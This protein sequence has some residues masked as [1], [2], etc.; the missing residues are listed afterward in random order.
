MSTQA[1][2]LSENPQRGA[3]NLG[4]PDPPTLANPAQKAPDHL[5]EYRTAREKRLAEM[6]DK[7]QNPDAPVFLEFESLTCPKSQ[8]LQCKLGVNTTNGMKYCR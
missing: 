1:T 3:R 7:R 2:V 8:F 4:I 6:W 5:H